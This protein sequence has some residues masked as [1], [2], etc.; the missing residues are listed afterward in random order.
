MIM[1]YDLPFLILLSA[2]R[3]LVIEIHEPLASL[4]LSHHVYRHHDP[5]C[6]LSSLLTILTNRPL[7]VSIRGIS[8]NSQLTWVRK[9]LPTCTCDRSIN[10]GPFAPHPW[11]LHLNK[12]ESIIHAVDSSISKEYGL[13]VFSSCTEDF[14]A[15]S[16]NPL[17]RE[18]FSHD[19][20]L[21]AQKLL[22]EVSARLSY[23]SHGNPT[24]CVQKRGHQSDIKPKNYLL[25]AWITLRTLLISSKSG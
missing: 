10:R 7:H 2:S 19:I 23:I 15:R 20:D 18:Q 13:S 22:L 8:C 21:W 1:A 11:I 6:R 9:S 24:F 12:E 17:A 4:L 16:L 14:P 3:S 5:L 25:V